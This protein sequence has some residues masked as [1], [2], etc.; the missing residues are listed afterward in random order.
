MGLYDRG[1]SRDM[2]NIWRGDTVAGARVTAKS[3]P[4]DTLDGV[5]PLE[6]KAHQTIGNV[7]LIL[8]P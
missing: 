3:D 4:H 6:I 8:S 1:E 7:P 2:E 5:P